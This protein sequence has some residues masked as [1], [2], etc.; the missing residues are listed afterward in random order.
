MVFAALAVIAYTRRRA[1]SRIVIVNAAMAVAF[2][3]IGIVTEN[4]S[5]G[6]T[7]FVTL[8]VVVILAYAAAV[9]WI[10]PLAR[11]LLRSRQD[12]DQP[13]SVLNTS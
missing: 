1:A 9:R 6:I 11:P 5:L 4:S 3:A 2:A 8:C 12:S 7:A 13:P 10:D